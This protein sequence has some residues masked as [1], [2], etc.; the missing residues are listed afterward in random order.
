MTP[1]TPAPSAAPVMPKA[2]INAAQKIEKG[3]CR[4]RVSSSTTIGRNSVET[5]QTT[6]KLKMF[7]PVTLLTATSLLPAKAAVTLTAS[8]GR[9]VPMET[10]VSPTI[11]GGMRSRRATAEA[12][13]TK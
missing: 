7:D 2:A 9:L 13:S 4:R 10:M 12:P 11:K 6:I 5:P 8:S 1:T 3:S